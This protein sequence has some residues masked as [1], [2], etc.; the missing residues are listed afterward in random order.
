MSYQSKI[1]FWIFLILT[2]ITLFF[3]Y[4]LYTLYTS[5]NTATFYEL[6]IIS[7]IYLII[8]YI[9]WLPIFNTVYYLKDTSIEVKSM[10]FKWSIPLKDIKTINSCTNF[11]SAPALSINKF[12]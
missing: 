9:I 7:I 5:I 3:L 6:L 10:F 8:F 1:D 2:S 4:T 11:I 12:E